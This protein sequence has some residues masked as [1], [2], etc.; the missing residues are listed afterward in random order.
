MHDAHCHPFDLAQKIAADTAKT[1]VKAAQIAF[2]VP[3]VASAWGKDDFLYN[4]SLA[5]KAKN[6]NAPIFLS[7][8]VH[9]QLLAA[10]KSAVS[11]SFALLLTFVQAK[12]LDAIGEIG[13]DL[14]DERYRPTEKEQDALFADELAVAMRYELPVILHVRKAMHKIFAYKKQLKHIKAV[15]F[16]GFSGTERDASALLA[17]GINASFSFGTAILNNHKK[18]QKAVSV[19]PPQR[20]LFETDA[21]YQ[22]SRGNEY[23]H[24]RDLRPILEKAAALRRE[25][26]SDFS[27]VHALE[28]LTDAQFFSLF[29]RNAASG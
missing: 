5:E 22:P 25:A 11:A 21:P 3:C 10:D 26:G 9:P 12:R 20:L 14:F 1:T 8:G 6:T 28:A 13:F 29:Q 2:A 19:I 16:H 4:E 24:Y 27:D 18:A 7:F 15:I 23:S 17:A